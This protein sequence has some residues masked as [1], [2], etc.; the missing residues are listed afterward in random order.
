MDEDVYY[1]QG[2]YPREDPYGHAVGTVDSRGIV[3][4][5]DG[6]FFATGDFKTVRVPEMFGGNFTPVIASKQVI[7]GT[8]VA[9]CYLLIGKVSVIVANGLFNWVSTESIQQFFDTEEE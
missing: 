4:T 3:E 2:G 8:G 9:M 6:T 1:N 5:A 7:H